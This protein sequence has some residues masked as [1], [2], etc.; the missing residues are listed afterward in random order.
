MSCKDKL[1]RLKS[2]LQ[3]NP[4]LAVDAESLKAIDDLLSGKYVIVPAENIRDN[5]TINNQDCYVVAEGQTVTTRTMT[6]AAHSEISVNSELLKTCPDK[7][8]KTLFE[9]LVKT[10]ENEKEDLE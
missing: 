2:F 4:Q 5:I 10:L 6:F 1:L 7:I 9:A 8:N 3:A